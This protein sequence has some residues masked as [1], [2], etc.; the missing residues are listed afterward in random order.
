M[1]AHHPHTSPAP[2]GLSRRTAVRTAAWS[3]PAVAIAAAAPA[4]AASG[5][6]NTW[7]PLTGAT[8]EWKI[9][10]VERWLEVGRQTATSLSGIRIVTSR[11]SQVIQPNRLKVNVAFP[12]RFVRSDFNTRDRN[13]IVKDV[14]AG[15]VADPPRYFLDGTKD[16]YAMVTFTYTQAL[17]PGG[18]LFSGGTLPLRFDAQRDTTTQHATYYAVDALAFTYTAPGFSPPGS[19]VIAIV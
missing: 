12:Y 1:N 6:P 5:A 13:M 19:G 11:S 15:W 17:Q 9:Q 16:R 10:G 18:G 14:S 4:F 8:A 7:F 2:H 3:V